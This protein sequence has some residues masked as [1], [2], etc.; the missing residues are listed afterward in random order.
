M[1]STYSCSERQTRE[2]LQKM[3]F[4]PCP[5]ELWNKSSKQAYVHVKDDNQFEIWHQRLAHQNTTH[6]LKVLK[7]WGITVPPQKIGSARMCSRKNE[8]EA[9]PNESVTNQGTWRTHSYESLWTYGK[10]FGWKLQVLHIIKGWLFTLQICIL[11]QKKEWS[12]RKV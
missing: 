8:Q 12:N 4:R 5:S 11:H 1:E 2:S 7:K 10:S 3:K 6:V 9:L